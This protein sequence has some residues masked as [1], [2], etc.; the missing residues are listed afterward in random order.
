M[1]IYGYMCRQCGQEYT[2][3]YRGNVLVEQGAQVECAMCTSEEIKRKYS[4]S[5]HRPMPRHF[6]STT[7]TE[8]GS[9]KQ[10]ERELMMQGE[11]AEEKSGIPTQYEIADPEML[12]AQVESNQGEGLDA[13][14]TR[15]MNEGKPPI[16]LDGKSVSIV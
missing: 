1:T 15:L 4:V 12:R 9:Q 6:N 13:T 16:R 11:M 14:N 2:S 7:Q 3:E 8:I 10:F 5:V